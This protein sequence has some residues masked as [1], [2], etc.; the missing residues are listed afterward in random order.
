MF[1]DPGQPSAVGTFPTI[2]EADQFL[3]AVTDQ[4]IAQVTHAGINQL[5]GNRPGTQINSSLGHFYLLEATTSGE[6]FNRVSI[7]VP[8][9]KI[10]SGVN[11]CRIFSQNPVYTALLFKYLTPV[12]LSQPP[13]AGYPVTDRHFISSMKGLFLEDQVL[14]GTSKFP[15]QPVLNDGKD[16]CLVVQMVQDLEGE[17]DTGRR[18]LSCQVREDHEHEIRV[19]AC[20]HHEP[21]GPVIGQFTLS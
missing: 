21:V 16:R 5:S 18:H 2:Q 17:I 12:Y 15:A 20:S 19:P 8:G 3:A 4:I 11:V 1:V 10:H 13:K 6:L 14:Q 9:V 7:P